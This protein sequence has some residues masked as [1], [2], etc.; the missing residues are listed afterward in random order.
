MQREGFEFNGMSVD[1]GFVRDENALK[2]TEKAYQETE[3]NL[4][5]KRNDEIKALGF[6]C[7][8][9]YVDGVMTLPEMSESVDG[10]KRTLDYLLVLRQNNFSTDYM[11]MQEDTL[12]TRL[13]EL[14]CIC[15]NMYIDK[16][17]FNSKVLSICDSISSINDEIK[18]GSKSSAW[19]ASESG[20]DMKAEST[21]I[22]L[23]NTP[24][25]ELK[26]AYSYGM[27]QIP[28]D[29]KEC[30]CGYRNRPEAR[31]CAKCGTKLS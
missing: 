9:L 10:I 30:T 26:E 16:R 5:I 4:K 17:L 24:Q 27:E 29:F 12:N 22:N 8:N 1:G 18:N 28:T 23:K 31:Y 14:G 3:K 19:S 20:A 25:S 15:Y 11:Q 6:L 13:T 7:Y 2:S 21:E